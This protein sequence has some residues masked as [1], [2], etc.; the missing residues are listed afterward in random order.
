M[1]N[2]LKYNDKNNGIFTLKNIKNETQN[3]RNSI[4]SENSFNSCI[5][6]FFVS[7]E[8]HFFYHEE[9]RLNDYS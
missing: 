1:K 3:S 2:K 8:E 4:N 5:S 9:K 7:K 6:V